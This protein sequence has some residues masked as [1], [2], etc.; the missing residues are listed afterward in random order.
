[1]QPSQLPAFPIDPGCPS[2]SS[3]RA[4]NRPLANHLRALGIHLA[5]GRA[6]IRSAWPGPHPPSKIPACSYM[7]SVPQEQRSASP[8]TISVDPDIFLFHACYCAYRSS[9]WLLSGVP[10]VNLFPVPFY[11]LLPVFLLPSPTAHMYISVSKSHRSITAPPQNPKHHHTMT[12]PKSFPLSVSAFPT[13][14]YYPVGWSWP[15][16]FCAQNFQ[17]QKLWRRLYWFR[18]QCPDTAPLKVHHSIS[19][20]FPY[21]AHPYRP[22]HMHSRWSAFHY[23]PTA[24]TPADG[25]PQILLQHQL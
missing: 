22:V 21:P 15:T 16:G 5:E 10:K 25:F 24:N 4:L 8:A 6:A 12:A 19:H 17:H 11:W 20:C 23:R 13:H 1:M 2:H 18:Q 9:D 7:T 3:E 14:T